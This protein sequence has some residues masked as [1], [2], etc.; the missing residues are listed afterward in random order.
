MYTHPFFA[1]NVSPFGTSFTRAKL[2]SLETSI[3]CHSSGNLGK[4]LL[5]TLFTISRVM[6]LVNL[7]SSFILPS[8][9]KLL[10]NFPLG[11]VFLTAG[12]RQTEKHLAR[13]NEVDA[14]FFLFE[15]IPFGATFGSNRFRECG[16]SL[17]SSLASSELDFDNLELIDDAL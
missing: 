6:L 16:K 14:T 13:P 15:G 10:R 9:F 8:D 5:I 4:A 12:S 1:H 2:L 7:I 3:Y 17:P 11:T